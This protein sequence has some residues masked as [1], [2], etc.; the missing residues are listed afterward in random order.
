MNYTILNTT[1]LKM[2]KVIALSGTRCVGKD[3]FFS[4]LSSINKF[5]VRFAFA[6]SLKNDLKSLVSDQFNID[7]FNPTPEEK[8]LIR[9]IL[10]SYGCTWRKIDINHW[11]KITIDDIYKQYY[12]NPSILPV[13]VDLRFQNEL[14]LLKNAFGDDLIHINISRINCIEPTDEEEKHYRQISSNAQYHLVWGNNSPEQ[15]IDMV[16]GLYQ[17]ILNR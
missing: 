2:M 8:E 1:K 9:P 13:I 12:S 11:V 7:I 15:R 6:D 5:C 16:N 17:N 14:D 10:I 4:A 3:A